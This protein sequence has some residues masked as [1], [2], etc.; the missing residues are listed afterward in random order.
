MNNPFAMM[1]GMPGLAGLVGMGGGGLQ[2]LNSGQISSMWGGMGGGRPLMPRPAMGMEQ[3]DD[4]VAAE[5]EDDMGVIETYSN[6]KP[7]KLDIGK[8]H[9]DPVVETASMA[10][11]EPPDVWYKLALPSEVINEGKLSALQLESIT[12]ASQQHE[13]MLRD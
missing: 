2:G 11:V 6:Y 1:G 7:M 13:Q 8:P 10:S 4:E 9:P 12:Y 5:D 3:E